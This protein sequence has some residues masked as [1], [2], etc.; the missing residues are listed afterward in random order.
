MSTLD[1]LDKE[2]QATEDR[3]YTLKKAKDILSGNDGGRGA[4][5]TSNVPEAQS[6]P[7]LGETGEIN[8]ED[9]DLPKKA[10]RNKPTIK[11][12]IKK[13]IERFG[14]REFTVNHVCA[15]LLQ[16]G[17]INDAKQSKN[18]ISIVIRELATVDGFIT[19]THKG[20]G[21]DPHRYTE[22]SKEVSFLK[23]VPN[24]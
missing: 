19:R 11:D 2:I 24:D 9:L 5:E 1:E 13:I 17:K 15:V 10:V 22:S 23:E 3:L 18:R 7:A 14:G 4:S 20:G 8:P 21:N 12:E 6:K 16:M